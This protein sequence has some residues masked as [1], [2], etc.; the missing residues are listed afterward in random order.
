[1]LF[2]EIIDDF[3]DVHTKHKKKLWLNAYIFWVFKPSRTTILNTWRPR[4]LCAL[5][6]K[7]LSKHIVA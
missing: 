3:S 6:N 1:M 4:C 5:L 2:M 7:V